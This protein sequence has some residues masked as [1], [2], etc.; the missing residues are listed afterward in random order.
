[1]IKKKHTAALV[2]LILL[3]ALLSAGGRREKETAGDITVTGRLGLTGNEP[4]TQLILE[5][6]DGVFYELTGPA[7]AD[8]RKRYTGR[9]VTVT[10]TLLQSPGKGP[11]QT[12]HIEVS[13]WESD[14]PPVELPA[15]L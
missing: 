5:A 11:I 9:Q 7:A 1:M 2:L 13:S 3:P 8:L 6:P 14:D 4:H 10:G 15:D 12:G